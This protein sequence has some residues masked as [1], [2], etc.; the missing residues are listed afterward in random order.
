MGTDGTRGL[1]SF[2]RRVGGWGGLLDKS[3]MVI[4]VPFGGLN[5]WLITVRVILIRFRVL[6]RKKIYDRNYKNNTVVED[7]RKSPKD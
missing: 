4:V 7:G 3:G 1:C 2:L 5:S 6:K